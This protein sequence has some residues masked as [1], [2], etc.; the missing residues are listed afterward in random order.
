MGNNKILPAGKKNKYHKGYSNSFVGIALVILSGLFLSINGAIGKQLGQELHPFFI[1]FIRAL[2]MVFFL[3]PWI[4]RHGRTGF[5]TTRPGLQFVNGFFF[6]L[7]L[8]GWFWALPRIPLDLVTAVGFTTPVFSVLGAIIFLGEKSERWRWGALIVSISGAII[9]IRPGVDGVS[10]GV[11]AALFSALCFAV[12]KLLTKVII[13]TDL[14]DS[15][16]FWQAFWVATIAAPVAV[17]YWTTPNF[18]QWLWIFGLSVI[19]I[20][21]HFALTWSLKL[22]DIGVIEPITF[23]RLLWASVTGYLVFGDEPNI[24]TIIGGAVVLASV[25]YIARREREDNNS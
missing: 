13:R 6:A 5:K 16:V 18:E 19:T 15:V 24:Y 12:T 11:S 3:L 22:A 21:N 1:T 20:I 7:A 2:I 8:F 9:I 14:P 23:T 25:I 17:Y 10:A 4:Y